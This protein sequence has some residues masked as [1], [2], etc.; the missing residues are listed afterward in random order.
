MD[1]DLKRK[2][3]LEGNKLKKAGC[4]NE[5]I[6]GRLDKMGIPEDLIK[7]VIT[8]LSIQERA[9]NQN[10]NAPFYN[11][12]LMRIGIGVALAVI[13]GAIFPDVTMLPI[14]LIGGGILSAILA[15]R[16]MNSPN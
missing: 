14:G 6:R 10:K 8:N 4:D 12:A 1:E 3:Y 5:V 7:Q 9:D 11:I 13:F 15:K 2:A 16:A